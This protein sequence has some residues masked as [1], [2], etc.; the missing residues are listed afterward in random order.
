[1]NN[2]KVEISDKTI[3]SAT[4]KGLQSLGVKRENSVIEILNEPGSGLL[5]LWGNKEA[6]V[7]VSIK[8]G[9]SE[10][11]KKIVESIVQEIDTNGMVS[12]TQEGNDIYVSIEG[13][14]MGI[15]IGKKGQTLESMQ[16]L[17]NV[18]L[19]RQFNHFKGRVIL[20]IENYRERR[21]N[22]LV[23]V[24]SETAERALKINREIE[25]EPMSSYERRII[26]M[27]LKDS[28]LVNTYSRGEEPY[29]KVVVSP[30]K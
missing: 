1:V 5:G 17:L 15:L 10:F 11:I 21:Q 19:H 18:I 24:A 16:Y 20:D 28:Q 14:S 12:L 9:P 2:E 25:L 6:K 8:L 23:K 4:E 7:S 26:H 13:K 30:V 3:E 29:R 27:A 22:V